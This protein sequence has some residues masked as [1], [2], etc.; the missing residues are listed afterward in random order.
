MK[1][2]DILEALEMRRNG[3]TNEEI[4]RYLLQC[5]GIP[6]QAITPPMIEEAIQANKT[7]VTALQAIHQ[8]KLN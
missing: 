5:A 3:K 4:G 2:E 6:P 8:R 7:F 1:P